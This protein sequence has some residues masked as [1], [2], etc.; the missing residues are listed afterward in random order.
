MVLSRMTANGSLLIVLVSICPTGQGATAADSAYWPQ[1]HGPKRDNMSTETGLLKQWPEGGP[2]L[3]WTAKGLGHGYAGVSIAD[4]QIYSA[5][6]IDDES[7]VTAMDMDGKTL[8]QTGC[9]PA[10]KGPYPG[11]RGTPT[12]DGD[13]VYYE[14]PLGDVVCLDAK[15]GRKIWGLNI[16]ERFQGK[17]IRWALSESLLVDGDRV[18]CCPGGEDACVAALDKMTGK[19]VWKCPGVGVQAGY[20]SPRLVEYQGLRIIIAL[21]LKAMVGVNADTGELLWKVE[22]V[23]LFDENV[24]TPVY[25]DGQVFVSSLASGSVKWKI[26]V[27]GQKASVEE[28]WR[29]KEMDNHHDGVILVGGHLYGST[30]ILNKGQWICL[31]WETGEKKYADKGVGK[32]S[33]TYADGMLYTLSEFG[34]VGLVQ[35]APG[36]HRLICQFSLPEQG[37]GKSWAHPVVCGGRLYIRHGDFLYAYDVRAERPSLR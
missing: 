1:F 34:R 5:G 17:N 10:W 22:H 16:L 8:W 29:S 6:N 12:I 13:R 31:D 11:T 23:S 26:H 25:H 30:A 37:E 33:V 2:E 7:V 14:T 21:M 35:P 32:G 36:S 20:A 28:L 4:G 27:D 15:T 19:L 3:L 18:I 24:L 9:G